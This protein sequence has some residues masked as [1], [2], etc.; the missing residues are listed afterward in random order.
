MLDFSS[1]LYQFQDMGFYDFVFPFLFVMVLIYGIMEYAGI[2]S[3]T[4]VKLLLSV[5]IS[6]F[7]MVYTPFG[8]YLTQM[9]AY[10][11]IFIVFVFIFT[12]VIGTILMGGGKDDDN[13]SGLQAFIRKYARPLWIIGAIV[14]LLIFLN[15]GGY[16]LLE[17]MGFDFSSVLGYIPFIL[18]GGGI[19]WY[20]WY[21][22]RDE[23]WVKKKREEKLK[24]IQKRYKDWNLYG[25]GSAPPWVHD[26]EYIALMKEMKEEIEKKHGRKW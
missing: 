11:T 20:I 3:K 24:N 10:S 7:V 12:L 18:I 25:G 21:L 1:I 4:G 16:E 2:F 5:L 6:F 26:P 8:P 9:L 23:E 19:V 15:S 13:V 17:G 14:V 22:G